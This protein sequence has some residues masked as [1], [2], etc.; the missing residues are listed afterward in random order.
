M[1]PRHRGVS[2]RLEP[3]AYSRYFHERN[4]DADTIWIG[5]CE[6]KREAA[7]WSRASFS[8]YV[9]HSVRSVMVLGPEEYEDRWMLKC[10][11]TVL[12]MWLE[13]VKEADLTALK[14][15]EAARAWHRR[16]MEANVL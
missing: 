12:A 9:E 6:R 13:L 15:K 8:D 4:V 7:A 10:A 14:G 5:L 1:N 16:Q 3:S 2:A 11:T